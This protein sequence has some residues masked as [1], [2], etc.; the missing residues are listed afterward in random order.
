MCG[1][2]SVCPLKL[3]T[4]AVRVLG[5]YRCPIMDVAGFPNRLLYFIRLCGNVALQPLAMSTAT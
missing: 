5:P 4:R 3:G 2:F 1:Y